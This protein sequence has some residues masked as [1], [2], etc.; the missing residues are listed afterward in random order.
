MD[1]AHS[2]PAVTQSNEQAE[3]TPKDPND[4]Q[5]TTIPVPP[6]DVA[7]PVSVENHHEIRQPPP[8][9]AQTAQSGNLLLSVG[10]V[11]MCRSSR[12]NTAHVPS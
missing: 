10:P 2:P 6:E 4:D 11:A 5:D 7:A 12:Y 8:S 1:V 9:D 3:L